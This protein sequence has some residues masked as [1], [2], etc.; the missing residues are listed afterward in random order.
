MRM[1]TSYHFIR[2]CINNKEMKLKYVKIPDQIVDIFT[3][4]PKFEDFWIMRASFSTKRGNFHSQ[5]NSQCDIDVW[6][7][8]YLMLRYYPVETN[9]Q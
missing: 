7:L 3:K 2:E 8:E 4:P 5:S 9:F 6:I 1:N